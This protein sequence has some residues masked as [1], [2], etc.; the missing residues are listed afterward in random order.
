MKDYVKPMV[1]NS[2]EVAESVYMASGSD[3][4]SV[5]ARFTQFPQLGNEVYIMQIDATHDASH[6]STGQV[7]T[8]TFNQAVEFIGCTGAGAHQISG[9]AAN[10]IKIGYTYHNNNSEAIGLGSLTVK[11]GSGLAVPTCSLSCNKTCEE[12]NQ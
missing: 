5:T 12:H 11:S 3:C 2:E 8:L 1:I 6:H 10:V 9:T 4:Y 7:L